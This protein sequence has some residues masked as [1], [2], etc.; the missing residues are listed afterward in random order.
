MK[1][2]LK[3]IVPL[4]I[5]FV[6]VAFIIA[7]GVTHDVRVFRPAGPV[8]HQERYLM[9][10]ALLLSAIVVVPTFA[11]TIFIAV[12][13]NENNKKPKKYRPDFDHSKLFEGIWW[14]VPIIIILILSVV[15]WN[16]AH[17]LDPYRQLASTKKPL[18]VQVVSLDWKWLFIYPDL[19]VA[20]VNQLAI[21]VNTPVSLDVTSDTIM[22]SFWIPSL[23]GQIYSMPGMITHLH[24]MA[25]RT[26]SFLGSPANIAGKGFARM[27]FT[28]KSLSQANFNQWVSRAAASNS[29]LTMS[30]YRRLAK[31]SSNVPVTYYSPIQDSLFQ[32]IVGKYLPASMPGM[33]MNSN[34]MGSGMPMTPASQTQGE[35]MTKPMTKPMANTAPVMPGM[36]VGSGAEPT[37]MQMQKPSSQPVTCGNMPAGYKGVYSPC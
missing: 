26:G 36:G 28:V 12:R 6:A 29:N 9:F 21:P 2:R 35:S 20:S 23:G 32:A 18:N 10:V 22:N 25:S 13:Y 7:W 8:A 27:D 37:Q 11:L 1:K 14:G 3:L 24:T 16:S 5:I 30:A 33:D 34:T 19:H 17:N 31:P 15:T 4:A